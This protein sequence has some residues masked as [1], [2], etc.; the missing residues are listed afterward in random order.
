LGENFFLTGPS[1]G[2]LILCLLKNLQKPLIFPKVFFSLHMFNTGLQFSISAL[3]NSSKRSHRHLVPREILLTFTTYKAPLNAL[4]VN[5]HKFYLTLPG[6]P[7]LHPCLAR[8]KTRTLSRNLAPSVWV[9][10]PPPPNYGGVANS[11]PSPH[12]FSLPAT[13]KLKVLFL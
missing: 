13:E 8:R 10:P 2:P 3:S 9:A 12:I 1:L 7:H 6:Y 11:K 4:V 5:L